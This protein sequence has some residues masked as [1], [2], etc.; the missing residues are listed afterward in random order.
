VIPSLLP[1][2]HADVRL[3]AFNTAF[4]DITPSRRVSGD[5]NDTCRSDDSRMLGETLGT[6]YG[7]SLLSPRA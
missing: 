2:I 5:T 7:N 4:R 6:R 3:V 1:F